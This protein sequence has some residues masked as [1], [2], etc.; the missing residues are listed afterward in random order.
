MAKGAGKARKKLPK[1]LAVV[2]ADNCTGCEACIEVCPVDCIYKVPGEDLPPL[3]T[4]V[5]IDLER[6]I[7]CALCERWC[8]WDAIEMVPTAKV[9]EVVATKG[10]PPAYVEKNQE[11]LVQVARQLAELY[12]EQQV[13][14]A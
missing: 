6:C 3:Q 5:D 12:A 9:H 7:G 11:R 14:K 2:F 10:G 1:E 13:P 4:F 8:P